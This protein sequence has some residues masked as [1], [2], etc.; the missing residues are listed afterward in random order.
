MLCERCVVCSVCVRVG[1]EERNG[2]T[3]C[4]CYTDIIKEAVN[5]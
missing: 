5:E 3:S 1:E 4:L 2:E